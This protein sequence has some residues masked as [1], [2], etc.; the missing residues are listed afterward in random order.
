[1]PE[2]SPTV[3]IVETTAG[4]PPMEF[5]GPSSDL[6]YFLSMAHSERYGA[7]HSLARAGF[8]LKRKLRINLSPLLSFG[9]ARA[10]SS[11]ERELLE[12]LWQDPAAVQLAARQAAEAIANNPELVDLTADFPDL[13]ERLMEL[14]DMAE[15]AAQQ[16]AQIRLTYIL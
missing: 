13:R 5:L 4:D 15:W 14:A 11:E 9:D 3:L 6:V 1:M 12:K 10:D 16:D 7:A 2:S 8:V